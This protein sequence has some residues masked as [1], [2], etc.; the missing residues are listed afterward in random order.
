MNPFALNPQV[1][2]AI[3]PWLMPREF[4]AA[5]AL[6][7]MLASREHYEHDIKTVSEDAVRFA[8]HLIEALKKSTP[9]TAQ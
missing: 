5:M 1:E 4:Y 2:L 3:K 7:G 9:T 6:C 8:D